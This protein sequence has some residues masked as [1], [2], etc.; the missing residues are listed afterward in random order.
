MSISV[1][2]IKKLWYMHT[3]EY[4]S[5]SGT[6]AILPFATTME[7]HSA[8]GTNAILP[9]ATTWVDLEGILL[10]EISQPERGKYCM[11]SFVCG[12]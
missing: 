2:C 3:M 6:N 9:F 4:H 8:S 12:V 11:V 7:Y 5:A 10:G 1:D